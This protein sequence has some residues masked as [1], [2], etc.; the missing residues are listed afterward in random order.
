M[1][2]FAFRLVRLNR[3]IDPLFK[4]ALEYN[5]IQDRLNSGEK[6]L[7]YPINPTGTVGLRTCSA[8]AYYLFL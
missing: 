4:I 7:W 5:F 1:G 8:Q 2:Y 6:I 3:V